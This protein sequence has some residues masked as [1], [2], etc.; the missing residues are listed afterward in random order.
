MEEVSEN[1]TIKEVAEKM[2][3]SETW[4]RNGL[5]QKRFTFGS[6]VQNKQSDT[7]SYHISRASFWL[8]QYGYIPK[9]LQKVV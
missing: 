2:G 8:Y 6:A 5:Q 9:E 1:M 3:R 4:V 7:W